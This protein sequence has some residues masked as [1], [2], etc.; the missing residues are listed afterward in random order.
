MFI[1]LIS[2][3]SFVEY[4]SAPMNPIPPQVPFR[5]IDRGL[6]PRAMPLE[7]PFTSIAWKCH[8]GSMDSI[9]GEIISAALSVSCRKNRSIGS[10]W[11]SLL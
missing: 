4:M 2:D 8:P 3:P 9:R 5:F 10:F 1:I 11:R 6:Y 7:R